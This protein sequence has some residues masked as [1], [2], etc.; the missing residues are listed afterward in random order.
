MVYQSDL[1]RHRNSCIMEEQECRFKNLGCTTIRSRKAMEEHMSIALTYYLSIV[2]SNQ[3]AQKEKIL[4]ME[5]SQRRLQA[6]CKQLKADNDTIMTKINQVGALLPSLRD[7]LK[8][9]DTMYFKLGQLI[10]VLTDISA[11]PIGGAVTLELSKKIT[12]GY[13]FVVIDTV[14]LQLEWKYGQSYLELQLFLTEPEDIPGTLTCE[15]IAQLEPH[16]EQRGKPIVKTLAV[17]CNGVPQLESEHAPGAFRKPIGP[18][19]KA[20]INSDTSLILNVREHKGPL[21]RQGALKGPLK[22]KKSHRKCGLH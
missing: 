2:L 4:S 5:K 10:T 8:V 20:F 14:V 17:V 1:T 18:E 11:V 6:E 21:T 22:P 7:S 3:E 9:G 13:H 15:F 19:K 16:E 12:K